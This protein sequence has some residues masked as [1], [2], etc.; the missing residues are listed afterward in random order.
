MGNHTSKVGNQ[1]GA[2]AEAYLSSAVHRQGA[3]LV[4]I[5]EK[6]K[7]RSI[8]RALDLGC[9]AGHLSFAIAPQV[10]SVTAY[11]LS[12]EM[13]G[14]VQKEADRRGLGNLM[15]QQGS[16]EELPFADESFDAVCTRFSAHHWTDVMRA[17]HEVRRV[18]K[19]DGTL[20]VID[21]CG[22]ANPLFD[23]HLQAIELLRDGSH[24]RNY[25]LREWRSM[26][27]EAGLHVKSEDSWKLPLDFEAW[28]G[29]MKTPEVYVNAIRSLLRNAPQEVREYLQVQEDS[30]FTP[31][32]VL[33]E[34]A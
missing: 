26:I 1:F 29:R 32:V 21:L 14:V 13:I 9:G 22:P 2:V 5:A 3:D 15:V 33:I 24:V 30:S 28:V 17:L 34:A 12:P 25:S 10:E 4:T 19:P 20:Y 11:D 23:T 31:D 16:V 18:L 8:G 7:S 6:L 27:Q